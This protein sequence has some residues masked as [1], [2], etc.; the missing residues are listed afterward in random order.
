M[1]SVSLSSAFLLQLFPLIFIDTLSSILFC[2][3][4]KCCVVLFVLL[5][6][7]E[8]L[9]TKLMHFCRRLKL[10]FNFVSLFTLFLYLHDFTSL[11]FQIHLSKVFKK[12]VVVLNFR[13]VVSKLEYNKTVLVIK[14]KKFTSHFV[15]APLS[16]SFIR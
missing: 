7:V 5:T 10:L 1:L 16:M 8:V 6:P 14:G 9:V 15:N 12:G 13:P 2:L 11:L 4:T 3:F